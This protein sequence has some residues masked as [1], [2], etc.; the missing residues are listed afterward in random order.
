MLGLV[1]TCGLDDFV[2]LPVVCFLVFDFGC[3]DCFCF[4]WGLCG[5]NFRFAVY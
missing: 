1:L 4:G 2:G 5:W 3:L